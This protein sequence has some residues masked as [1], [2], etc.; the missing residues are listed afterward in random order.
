MIVCCRESTNLLSIQLY[1]FNV[2]QNGSCS[3]EIDKIV[4]CKRDC[5]VNWGIHIGGVQLAAYVVHVLVHTKLSSGH[6]YIYSRLTA[7]RRI[8]NFSCITSLK[9]AACFTKLWKI[10]LYSGFSK[11]ILPKVER[12][13][14][15]LPLF[16]NN[17]GKWTFKGELLAN[18]YSYVAEQNC[19]IFN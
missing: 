7:Y 14:L 1:N 12:F 3:S 16:Q 18:A 6:F 17:R 19:K 4:G 9:E 15:I 2:W 11:T 10:I 5:I 8:A 13:F